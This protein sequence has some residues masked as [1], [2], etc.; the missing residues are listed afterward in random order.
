MTS[1]FQE[2]RVN[3]AAA[4]D[5]SALALPSAQRQCTKVVQKAVRHCLGGLFVN[6]QTKLS[7]HNSLTPFFG[8]P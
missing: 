1:P 5:Y 3:Q 6:K 8:K 2:T 7:N 4:T